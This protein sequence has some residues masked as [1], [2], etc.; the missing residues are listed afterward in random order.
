[1]TPS[2]YQECAVSHVVKKA[3]IHTLHRMQSS[4]IA[5]EVKGKEMNRT[6]WFGT[7]RCF[8]NLNPKREWGEST[9]EY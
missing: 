2:A 1:M 4:N 7:K 8:N 3:K 9:W 5:M 6:Y